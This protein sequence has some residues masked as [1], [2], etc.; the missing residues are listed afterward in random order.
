MQSSLI[1]QGNIQL[2]G[3]LNI[4][5]DQ[6]YSPIPGSKFQLIQL[7][8]NSIS[9]SPIINMQD[10]IQSYEWNKVP[11]LQKGSSRIIFS[12]HPSIGLE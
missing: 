6:S 8:N 5:I 3:K 1:L 7:N 4:S 10:L 9:G 11:L 12:G 2:N